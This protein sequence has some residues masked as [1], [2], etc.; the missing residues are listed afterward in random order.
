MRACSA[1]GRWSAE[2]TT[3]A[4]TTFGLPPRT[5]S[6]DYTAVSRGLA[7]PFISLSLSI[8]SAALSLSSSLSRPLA[9][10]LSLYITRLQSTPRPR[11]FRLFVSTKTRGRREE[12]VRRDDLYAVIIYCY[13]RLWERQIYIHPPPLVYRGEIYEQSS[14]RLRERE[15]DLSKY[16]T[17]PI[18]LSVACSVTNVVTRI[19]LIVT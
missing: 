3:A 9:L 16:R 2:S 6:R 17:R 8:G 15:I 4:H 1:N 14:M 18:L 10:R 5:K 19:L 12:V 13:R 11:L 7:R